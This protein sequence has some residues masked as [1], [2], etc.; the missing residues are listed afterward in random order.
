MCALPIA[1]ALDIARDSYEFRTRLDSMRQDWE[2]HSLPFAIK[3]QLE[4]VL[5]AQEKDNI[6]NYSLRKKSFDAQFDPNDKKF[7]EKTEKHRQ[8]VEVQKE[9]WTQAAIKDIVAFQKFVLPRLLEGSSNARTT[10]PQREH[11]RTS[12]TS[13]DTYPDVKFMLTVA[14]Y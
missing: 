12:P 14:R 7:D 10:P 3:F 8:K 11:R 13:H 9:A 4:C 5:L 6:K 1:G 2:K